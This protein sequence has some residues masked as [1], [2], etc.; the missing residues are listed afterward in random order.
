MAVPMMGELLSAAANGF[1]NEDAH[2]KVMVTEPD[3]R[4]CVFYNT[5]LN[6]SS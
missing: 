2:G 5:R 4:L 6:A 1:I 3:I